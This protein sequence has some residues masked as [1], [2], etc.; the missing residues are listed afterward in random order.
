MS[1]PLCLIP[2]S[3]PIQ[4]PCGQVI[5]QECVESLLLG[6]DEMDCPLCSEQHLK[7]QMKSA[8]N[9]ESSSNN[10][11]DENDDNQIN[12]D[13]CEINQ[14]VE[15]NFENDEKQQNQ[16]MTNQQII[17][18]NNS[19]VL[20]QQN[21]ISIEKKE[22][23]KQLNNIEQQPI[24]PIQ[25]SIKNQPIPNINNTD[26]PNNNL[27]NNFTINTNEM[28]K[29]EYNI[30][31]STMSFDDI[32][33]SIQQYIP[34]QLPSYDEI[35]SAENPYNYPPNPQAMYNDQQN[36]YSVPQQY[37]MNPQMNQQFNPSNQQNN[38][39]QIPNNYQYQSPI[40]NQSQNQIESQQQ[41]PIQQKQKK[42]P[43]IPP[44]KQ[45]QSQAPPNLPPKQPNYTP[46]QFTIPPPQP[47]QSNEQQYQQ[48]RHEYQQNPYPNQSQQQTYQQ[49]SNQYN[50]YPNL[51]QP[52]QYN[53]YYN[54][55]PMQQNYPPQQ[56]NN[57]PPKN[58]NSPKNI[59]IEKFPLH[60]MLPELSQLQIKQSFTRWVNSG[61]FSSRKLT[62]SIKS[63]SLVF[64]DIHMIP[65]LYV[66]VVFACNGCIG[67]YE[68]CADI[69]LLLWESNSPY[70]TQFDENFKIPRGKLYR[71]DKNDRNARTLQQILNP[72]LMDKI[73]GF[74]KTNEMLITKDLP[75]YKFEDSLDPMPIYHNFIVNTMNQLKREY[76][77]NMHKQQVTSSYMAST[78]VEI[79]KEKSFGRRIYC[80]FAF[81][82][83]RYDN[84][85]HY[86][87]VN[88][89]TGDVYGEKKK[90]FLG[91][92]WGS[93]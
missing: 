8:N 56:Y 22:E 70:R 80:P 4:L 1:C 26:T 58:K 6:S 57:Q 30:F 34:P 77:E 38:Q 5:C 21:E 81:T 15:N 44:P 13:N 71:Y 42:L 43:P 49:Y 32:D 82:S 25:E 17:Q 69:P 89:I 83:Y 51:S 86:C 65:F 87:L 61:L 53:Q 3:E 33:D 68:R 59:Q 20:N 19:V 16:L 90:S 9:D 28:N 63:Q 31:D 2:L 84:Q 64:D 52:N 62:E 55:Q 24:Q 41:Q 85:L 7:S 14:N 39:Y 47:N 36:M 54:Q 12:D 66:H 73:G 45:K 79:M 67:Y 40:Q 35:Y 76:N 37:P 88:T 50:P 46:T 74:F 29:E 72:S 78:S 91:F 75:K 27:N 18:S 93:R 92:E 11:E 48:Q 60:F 10:S 23:P